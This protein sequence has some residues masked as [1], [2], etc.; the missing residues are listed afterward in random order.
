MVDPRIVARIRAI[1]TGFPEVVEQRAWVGDRWRIRAATFA[2]VLLV[3]HGA[4]A[5]YARAI[6]SD[7]IAVPV[8]TFSSA[9]PEIDALERI[10]LPFFRPR[11]S[12]SVLGM[13]LP[14]PAAIDWDEVVELLT[15]SYC[16]RAPC[17]LAALVDRP[18][19]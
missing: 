5:S 8:L 13:V 1:C 19:D 14:D 6:G 16:L 3:S 11:W 7:D 4:P 17:R 9:P 10:G 2:H 12:A 15:E 18:G